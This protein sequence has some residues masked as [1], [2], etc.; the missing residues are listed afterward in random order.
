MG[1]S[2]DAWTFVS[3]EERD[4]VAAIEKFMATKVKR[5]T[6]DGFDYARR[7]AAGSARPDRPARP[8]RPAARGSSA[9]GTHSP[10]HHDASVVGA[11]PLADPSPQAA[12]DHG[13]RRRLNTQDRRSRRRM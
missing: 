3:P 12:T 8:A 1:D 2:G 6:L 9:R 5:V 4:D 10:R 11:G 7:P 13:R